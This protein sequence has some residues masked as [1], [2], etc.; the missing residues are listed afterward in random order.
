M[1]GLGY[2]WRSSADSQ[3]KRPHVYLY[4]E[5]SELK[6]SSYLELFEGARI[7]ATGLVAGQSVAIML[8]TS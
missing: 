8:P 2:C 4:E 6:V 7:M 1:T 3:P 5:G